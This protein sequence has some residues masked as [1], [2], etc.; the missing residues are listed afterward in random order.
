MW[1]LMERAC[2]TESDDQTSTQG[3]AEQARIQVGQICE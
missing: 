2:L 1:F 3:E